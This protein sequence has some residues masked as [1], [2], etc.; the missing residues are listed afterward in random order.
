MHVVL[1]PF[2]CRADRDGIKSED[3]VVGDVRD[4]AELAPGLL[5]E[6]FIGAIEE[7]EG[8]GEPGAIPDDWRDLSAADLRALA[9]P[10]SDAPL[11][12]RAE[13]EA[14]ILAELAKRA[15]A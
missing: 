2:P 6:G 10:Y 12:N 7:K 3:L 13:S 15:A 14:A 8:A 9:Q 5:A 1:K 11:K 4:F